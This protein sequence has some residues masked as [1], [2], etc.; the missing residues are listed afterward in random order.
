VIYGPNA[1]ICQQKDHSL[2]A[3]RFDS[4]TYSFAIKKRNVKLRLIQ[5]LIGVFSA[6]FVN[7]SV[8]KNNNILVT[9]LIYN[10]KISDNNAESGKVPRML[11]AFGV[12]TLNNEGNP[13]KKEFL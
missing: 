5:N 6:N 2:V 3:G 10:A 9:F 8:L 13:L 1:I 12:S 4:L 7:F 11:A